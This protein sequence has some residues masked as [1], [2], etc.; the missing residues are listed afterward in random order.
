MHTLYLNKFNHESLN[1][2]QIY[3]NKDG[4]IKISDPILL[5]LEKNYI[6]VL[7]KRNDEGTYLSPEIM[8]FLDDCNFSFYDKE[9]SDV[10]VLGLIMLEASL[11][12]KIE[13][14][15]TEKKRPKL[16]SLPSFLHEVRE[17]YS[18]SYA[19][20]LRRMLQLHSRHRPKLGEIVLKI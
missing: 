17:R 19:E 3:I 11:L 10:F 6:T 16:E 14:Y 4:L 1:P 15:D 7:K 2:K 12:K 8:N 9:T 20:I 5:G 18:E 13:L